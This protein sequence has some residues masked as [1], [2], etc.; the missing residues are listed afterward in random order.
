MRL[1]F[2]YASNILEIK[3]L[4][5]PANVKLRNKKKAVSKNGTAF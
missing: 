3:I 5:C 2:Y 1:L 4:Y